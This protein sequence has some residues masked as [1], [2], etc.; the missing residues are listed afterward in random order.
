M[1]RF[2]DRRETATTIRVRLRGLQRNPIL[3]EKI[4]RHTRERVALF[5]RHQK[6]VVTAVGI[7]LGQDSDVSDENETRIFDLDEFFLL[8]VPALRTEEEQTPLAS[9]ISRLLQVLAE[10]ER[11]IIRFPLILYRDVLPFGRDP[12][13]VFL[14]EV[15]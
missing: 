12:G 8:G 10:I 15:V 5:D 6:N 7:F 14:V 1:G 9:A 2:V 3:A 13:N 4:N 11:G